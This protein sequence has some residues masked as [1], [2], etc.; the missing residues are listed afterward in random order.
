MCG[1]YRVDTVVKVRNLCACGT[2]HACEA[3]D[4]MA[5]M[6]WPF[7]ASSGYNERAWHHHT[8]VLNHTMPCMHGLRVRLLSEVFDE[9]HLNSVSV[10]I[11]TKENYAKILIQLVETKCKGV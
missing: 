10:N 2:Y 6:S 4:G 11:Y 8:L 5:G 7:K 9:S 3:K 1:L